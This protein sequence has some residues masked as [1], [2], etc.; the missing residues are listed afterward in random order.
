MDVTNV[1]DHGT[2]TGEG[3]LWH[4]D[5]EVVYWLD[6][7]NGRLFRYDPDTGD[8]GKV[9]DDDRRIGG[10]TIQADGDLLLFM[11]DG[12]VQLWNEADGL[13]DVLLP[14]IPE[15]EGSRFNDVIA[16]PE[17]RV[18]AG[19]MAE[20]GSRGRLYRFDTDGS[21][22]VL[23]EGVATANGM[24]FSPDNNRFYFAETNEAT[25]WEFDFDR[26]T[27]DLRNRREFVSTVGSPG[28][29][30]GL[31]VDETGAVW[32]ARWNGGCIV[33]YGPDGRE[34]DRVRFPA[35]KV[36]TVTF[37]GPDYATAY[38]PT[39]TAGNDRD[40]EGDGAGALFAFEPGVNG[41]PEF[42]S[43]IDS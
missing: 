21:F 18:Y 9:H 15:E 38:V 39:A 11:D 37:G 34:L 33:R 3:A 27:G 28:K 26:E 12:E 41:L 25:V 23:V 8:H 2:E 31:T 13:G 40:V 5:E 19:T 20:G 43:R 14:G 6:I 1:A 32:T 16:G 42:R 22:D 30:D 4:P 29:P 17:G 7:P 35:R 10:F 24:G 36:A